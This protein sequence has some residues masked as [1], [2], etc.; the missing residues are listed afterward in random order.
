MYCSALYVIKTAESWISTVLSSKCL[1][2][3]FFSFFLSFFLLFFLSSFLSFFFFPF[4]L[5]RFFPFFFLSCFLSIT[6]FSTP[7]LFCSTILPCPSCHRLLLQLLILSLLLLSS[8]CRTMHDANALINSL[9]KLAVLEIQ[10]QLEVNAHTHSHRVANTYIH[11]Y[12][13]T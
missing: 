1:L 7:I 3:F 4:F 6:F 13:H 12:I 10:S 2:S 9:M 8:T 11:T 5:S